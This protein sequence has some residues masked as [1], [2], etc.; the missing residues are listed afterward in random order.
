MLL[1]LP[2]AID[3]SVANFDPQLQQAFHDRIA[4]TMVV[5]TRRGYSLDLKVKR[6]VAQLRRFVK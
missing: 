2:L 4:G 1:L 6:W 3:C 5:A